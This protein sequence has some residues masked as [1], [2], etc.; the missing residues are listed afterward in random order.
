MLLGEQKRVLVSKISTEP[1]IPAST[2]L[3]ELTFKAIIIAIILAVV[4][5]ASNAYLALK[6][7]TT[8]SASIPASVLAL[9]ILRFFKRSNVLESNIIQTA[10]SAGEGVAAAVAFILPAMI[11]LHVWNGFSYWQTAIVSMLGGL[12]GVLFSIPLRRVM[13]NLP[14]LRFPEGT[15]IGNV[16]ITSTKKGAFLINLVLGGAAGGLISLCQG[17]FKFVAETLQ[18]WSFWGSSFIGLNIGLTPATLA[19]GYIIGIEVGITL[20]TGVIIGWVIVLP[21]IAQHVGVN[22][23]ISAYSNAMAL[24]SSHLRFVG[25]GT[26]LVGGVWT[27][28]RLMKPVIS[29]LKDSF[30]ELGKNSQ[31]AGNLKVLRTERD[32][33]LL[34]VICGSVF[35]SLLIYMFVA[36]R[37]I[38][39]SEV[40]YST[41]YSLFI[42]FC[43]ILYVIVIGF[44]LATVCGYFTGLIGSTN[45]P[46]SGILIIALL[47]LS[48]MY[49]GL[50]NIDAASTH[51]AAMVVLVA[52]VVATIGSISNENLQDLKAG[53][54]VGSTPWKQQVM[55]GIGVI[56][57]ALVIGPVL[58]LL[59]HAYGMAG[60]FPR[61]GMDPAQMLA[62]PQASLMAAVI[63]GVLLHKLDWDMILIG[64]GIAVLVIIVDEFIKRWNFRLPALALGLGIYLPP[65]IITPIVIGGFISYLVKRS[66]RNK[67]NTPEDKVIQHDT[68]QRG[69]LLACGMVAG[70]ALM[71]VILAIPFVIMGSSDALALVPKTFAPVASVLGAIVLIALCTWFYRTARFRR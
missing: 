55:L 31:Q 34:W 65:E 10:A 7:G 51:V 13:L 42:A 18:F 54:M 64:C 48:L 58:N 50:F 36:N 37:I 69:I 47:L 49:A 19:A 21:L 2:K 1:L 68:H 35:L 12:L 15:A 56:V 5:A 23:S 17:G 44:M 9:G 53:Q 62:A 25:V 29:G 32:I 67:V 57:A 38:N 22:H 24:W 3:P 20:L 63:N 30:S 59:F 14:A 6:I 45:N 61:P 11:V 8:I 16:L 46:L 27:L 70:S 41:L 33:S 40:H 26:M 71:G 66:S 28:V 43:T 39:I 60:V 52:T 4:L